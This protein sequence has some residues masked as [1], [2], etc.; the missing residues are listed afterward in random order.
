MFYKE[1]IFLL[2]KVEGS[3]SESEDTQINKLCS[4]FYKL[5]AKQ[6]KVNLLALTEKPVS[7]VSSTSSKLALNPSLEE[8]RDEEDDGSISSACDLG[9]RAN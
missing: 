2:N 4:D 3:H 5:K 7:S 8:Q 9:S 6:W 1:K